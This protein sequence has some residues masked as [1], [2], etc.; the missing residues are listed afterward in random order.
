MPIAS[1]NSRIDIGR[2]ASR[3]SARVR[4]SP[5]AAPASA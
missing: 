4:V 5:E 1:A 2:R 3:R